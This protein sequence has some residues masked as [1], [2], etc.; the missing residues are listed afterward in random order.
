MAIK[1]FIFSDRNAAASG[2]SLEYFI[3]LQMLYY[4]GKILGYFNVDLSSKKIDFFYLCAL[5][6]RRADKGITVKEGM[7]RRI[8]ERAQ[9]CQLNLPLHRWMDWGWKKEVR[10]K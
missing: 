1:L 6:K 10:D 2:D 4:K 8:Y 9:G 3:Q 5:P 7:E